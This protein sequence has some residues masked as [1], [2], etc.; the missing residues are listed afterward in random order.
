MFKKWQIV[1]MI[2]LD[3]SRQLFIFTDLYNSTL[4]LTL[5]KYKTILEKVVSSR[6]YA[7]DFHLMGPSKCGITAQA[8]RTKPPLPHNTQYTITII[9]L[10]GF[11]C[12]PSSASHYCI[13]L[14]EIQ[15]VGQL[16]DN[17]T[18][19][20]DEPFI[21]SDQTV[22]FPVDLA[23]WEKITSFLFSIASAHNKN[24]QHKHYLTL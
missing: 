21:I 5:N 11:S 20:F 4:Y 19:R 16:I 3:C 6:I 9:T 14:G 23:P 1:I 18:Q 17:A 24:L 15:V 2:Y 22:K 12:L 10:S 13:H 7:G 8:G